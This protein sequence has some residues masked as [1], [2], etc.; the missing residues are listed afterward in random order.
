MAAQEHARSNGGTA[1]ATPAEQ[2][3]EQVSMTERKRRL[4][5]A[6]VAKAEQGYQIESQTD[7]EATLVTQ[8]KRRWFGMV[9]SSKAE[10][11]QITSIDELGRTQTRAL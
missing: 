5:E 10:A 2:P 7:T 9:G 6:L 8:G 11:R 1:I 4:A 3:L